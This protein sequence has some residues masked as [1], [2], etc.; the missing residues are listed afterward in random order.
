MG[1]AKPKLALKDFKILATKEPG[2]KDVLAR[3][4][5]CEKIVKRM[6]FEKAIESDS[7]PSAW[8]G[9]N[10]DDLGMLVLW[11]GTGV[12]NLDVEDGYDGYRLTGQMTWEF[13]QD[14]IQRFKDNKRIHKNYV[15]FCVTTN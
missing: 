8:E 3:L 15:R 9:I 11:I 1:I 14:M 7:A 6:Q 13:V 4:N 2:N 5:E 10:V 12:A